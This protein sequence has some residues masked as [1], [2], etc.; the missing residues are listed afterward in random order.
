MKLHLVGVV[1]FHASKCKVGE[2]DVT[3]LVA[4]FHFANLPL[5]GQILLLLLTVHTVA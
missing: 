4:V 5:E 1:L 2:T 3:R